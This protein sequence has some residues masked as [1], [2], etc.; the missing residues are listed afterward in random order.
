[1]HIPDGYLSPQTCA[2][3]GASMV[4]LWYIASR[5]VKS[6][7][8]QGSVALMAIGAA[9]A[10]VIMM[11]NVPVPDGTTAHATGGVL[12]AVALGPWAAIISMSIALAIQALFFGDGGILAFPAN[13]FNM[14]VAGPLVGY[15]V[16]RLV[17]GPSRAGTARQWIGAAAG[18][19]VGINVAAVLTAVEFGLQP[20]LF[21][22]SDGTPL[23]SPYRLELALPAML[24][25]HL[26]VAGPVEAVVTGVAVAYLRRTFP[27]L[28]VSKAKSAGNGKK[29]FRPLWI[30]LSLLVL[31]TPLGLLAQGPAWGEWSPEE[32]SSVVGF[33]PKGIEELSGLWSGLLPD[34]SVPGWYSGP[35]AVA[36]YVVSALLGMLLVAGVA[37]GISRLLTRKQEGPA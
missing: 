3:M 21:T 19:Y 5:K 27:E 36:G 18:A 33:V 31:L 28:V 8:K 12:L 16:Y 30:A 34:Y 1:V 7:F 17:A 20:V 14:A 11:F 22:T 23:Y 24:F 26:L 9:F 29:S 2:V 37:L 25:A 4:P 10:F 15:A 35:L 6:L 32:L 13:A